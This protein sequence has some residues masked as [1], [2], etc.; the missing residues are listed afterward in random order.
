MSPTR[1]GAAAKAAP[2]RSPHELRFTVAL[3]QLA[4]AEAEVCH[5]LVEMRK[6]SL[7][8]V[9]IQLSGYSR[10]KCYRLMATVTEVTRYYQRR[11]YGWQPPTR[12][13]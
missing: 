4:R 13:R 6:H 5:A 11:T 2:Q 3:E 10:S 7:L 8:D 1:K 9:A 12:N